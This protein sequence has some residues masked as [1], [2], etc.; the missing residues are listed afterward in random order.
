M[1]QTRWARHHDWFIRI[2]VVNGKQAVVVKDDMTA[3]SE[4]VFTSFNK[5]KEWAGY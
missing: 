2:D 3:G 4:L 1:Y 5:L